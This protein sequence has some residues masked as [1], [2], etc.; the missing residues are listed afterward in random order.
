MSSNYPKINAGTFVHVCNRAVGSEILF[1]RR[2]DSEDWMQKVEKYI[3][4]VAE[5]HAFSLMANH[6]H[7]VLRTLDFVQHE[8]LSKQMNRLQSTY[9]IKYNHVY[10][11][12]GGLFMRPFNRVPIMNDAQLLWTIWYVHRN[13]LHHHVA[14]NWQEWKYSSYPHYMNNQ[15]SIITTKFTL[16]LFGGVDQMKSHHNMNAQAFRTDHQKL[17]LE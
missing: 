17:S 1:R 8:L 2:E 13:P 7:Y 15:S 11:R 5:I 12:K 10:Q 3:L 6:F 14:E 16:A 4:P 9:S